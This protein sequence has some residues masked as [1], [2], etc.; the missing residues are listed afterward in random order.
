[1]LL[2]VE[3]IPPLTEDE[4]LWVRKQRV[5]EARQAN[6]PDELTERKHQ[7]VDILEMLHEHG[8]DRHSLDHLTHSFSLKMQAWQDNITE[9][10]SLIP[11]RTLSMEVQLWVEETLR[12]ELKNFRWDF[13]ETNAHWAFR[14]VVA[15]WILHQKAP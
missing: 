1:M 9:P 3:A 14:D 5:A 8:D 7:M 4:I 11:S 15:H 2:V 10:V 6:P 12:Q 13:A